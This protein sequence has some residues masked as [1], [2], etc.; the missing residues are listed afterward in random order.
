MSNQFTDVGYMSPE[1]Y[2]DLI[3]KSIEV[4]WMRRDEAKSVL[5]V[6]FDQQ[7]VAS[8]STK[9]SSVGSALP[10]PRESQDTEEMPVAIPAP[11]YDQ[12]FTLVNYR[13]AIQVTDTMIRADRFG[14]IMGMTGGLVKAAD[15]RLEYLRAGIINGA[16]AST[17]GADASYL[18]ADAHAEVNPN[19]ATWDN[20]GTGALTGANLQALCLLAAN[21]TDDVGCPD[22]REIKNLLVPTALRQKALELTTATL[23][24]ETALNTPTVVIKGMNVVVS[25][26]LTSATAYIGFAEAMGEE[27]GLLEF[28]LMKPALANIGDETADIPIRKRVKFIVK[29]GA[30][31]G[32][33]VYGSTGT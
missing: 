1:A 21:M 22:Q 13:L 27:K 14:K 18:C 5:G 23:T 26:H 11:G 2:V 3:D 7:T 15:R 31:Q 33:S 28:Y 9:M 16:F 24:A 30:H 25:P 29:V 17:T 6:F 20:L 10:M 12:S 8:L 4:M 32:K 19:A